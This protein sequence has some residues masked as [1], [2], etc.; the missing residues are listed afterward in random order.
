MAKKKRVQDE[1]EELEQA[2][3]S[4]TGYRPKVQQTHRSRSKKLIFLCFALVLILAL[5]GLFTITANHGSLLDNVLKMNSVTIG[6]INMTGLTKAEAKVAL[7]EQALRLGRE[8]MVI[9]VAD[10]TLV[11]SPADIGIQ[12]DPAKAVNAA[13]RENATGVFQWTPYLNLNTEFLQ[14]AVDSLGKQYNTDFSQTVV[15]ITGERPALEADAAPTEQGMVLSI[16]IGRPQ[17]GLD[18]DVLYQQILDAYNNGILT[19]TGQFSMLEP[20]TPDLDAIYAQSYVAPVNASM[21]PKTF[22]ISDDLYGYHFDLEAAK[23]ELAQAQYG[24][25]L[26]IP[27][28]KIAPTV[29]AANLSSKLFCDVL[30]SAKTPYSGQDTN[31]RNTNIA[32]ACEAIN[33]L[34]LLPGERFSY[35]DTLGE[36]TAEAGYKKAP[37][38]VDGLTVDTYGGG[39]CQVSSTLYYSTLFADLE[40]LERYN[41]GYISNYIDKGMD[42][43]VTWGGAD[44]RFANNT[45]YPIRIEAH[46]ADG[47]VNVQIL[48]TDERDYYVKMSYNV[49][50]R[51][52]YETVYKDYLPDNPEGYTDGKVIVTPYDGYIVQ[53]YKAKYS[54]ETDE[55]LS[56]EPWTYDIYKKRDKV[57]CRITDTPA[58]DAT[59]STDA[60]EPTEAIEATESTEAKTPTESTE[61]AE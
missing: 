57:I 14:S 53:T 12:P 24:Q 18:T 29:T 34:I 39:I 30:G 55:L 27:F 44:L 6:G 21:D 42:A 11:L 48:G 56:K 46:R 31:N 10:T 32:L 47:Y 19:V 45:N 40:I 49:R 50:E 15:N 16:T 25:T 20:E 37:S 7:H 41:H 5:C 33:G 17:Y 3:T 52:P 4:I 13:F 22:V 8:N 51:T 36:R 26:E 58:T 28:E 43:T 23:A 59:G 9:Q 1:V 2:Y 61:T 54:K 38:Y 60:T 35:N